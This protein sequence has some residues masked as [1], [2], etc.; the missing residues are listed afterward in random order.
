[1]SEPVTS[2]TSGEALDD[3]LI[4]LMEQALATPEDVPIEVLQQI[5]TE[6]EEL[7]A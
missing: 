2:K 6:I 7:L 1:M 5:I 3:S 4:E